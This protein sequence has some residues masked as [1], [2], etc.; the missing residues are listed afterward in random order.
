M[1]K[2]ISKANLDRITKALDERYK[3]LIDNEK[4]RAN[5]REDAIEDLANQA[6]DMFGGKSIRYI[7][8]AEY[9][10]LTEEERNS[11]EITY[12]I[13]DVEDLSHEHENKE[14][15]DGLSQE[16][17]DNEYVKAVDYDGGEVYIDDTIYIKKSDY[18]AKIAELEE[19]ISLLENNNE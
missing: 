17:L 5:V 8:Q 16:V 18:D 10:V 11:D 2:L 3:L 15:L 4:N 1:S 6:I 19:R 9:D 13:T 7:T 14:F 12:F